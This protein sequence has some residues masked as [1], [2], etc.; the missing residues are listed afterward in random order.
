MSDDYGYFGS[1]PTGY[2]HY[3]AADN[4]GRGGKRPSSNSGCLTLSLALLAGLAL[5]LI[6]I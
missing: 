5:L 4:Y 6:L 1:G 3:T 2:A